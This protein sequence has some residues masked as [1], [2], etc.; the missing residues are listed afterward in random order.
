MLSRGSVTIKSTNIRDDPIVDPNFLSH[1]ND[2]ANLLE[3]LRMNMRIVSTKAFREIETRPFEP[4][5]DKC[6]HHGLWSDNYLKCIT[7]LESGTEWHYC[8]TASMGN[9]SRRSVV[10]TRLRVHGVQ[11][12]RI[13]DASIMPALTRANTNAPVMM[14]AE[15]AADLIKSDW[16]L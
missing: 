10:D 2:V 15:K 5:V 1:P 16:K 8:C 7:V 3:S 4:I 9:D 12:L 14:I 13:V 6:R 11:G